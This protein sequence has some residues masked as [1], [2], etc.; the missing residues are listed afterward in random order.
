MPTL[1]ESLS[2]FQVWVGGAVVLGAAVWYLGLNTPSAKAKRAGA[3]LAPGPKRLPV[4]GNLFNFPKRKWYDTFTRWAK[5]YGDITYVDLAGTSMIVLN[6][7]GAIRELTEKRMNIHSNRVHATLVC[8]LMGSAYF[9]T[10]MQPTK[11]FAEQ[12]RLF[13][14][15]IGPRIVEQYDAFIQHGCSEL[16][17]Q[18]D[19]F[20]GEPIG[21]LTK[22]MGNVLTRIAYGERFFEQH[23]PEIIKYNIEGVE[24]IS[25]A[26]TQFWFVDVIPTLRYVPAWFP[27]AH[28][29]RVGNQGKYYSDMIRYLAFNRVKANMA[30]GLV[31][32]SI[33]SK[34][35]QEGSISEDNLRDAVAT[36]Y[37]AGV[38][39]TTITITHFLFSVALY[40]EWQQ[41]IHQE[42]DR[43]LGR[44]QLPTLGDTSKLETF[45]A[46]F[47]E[48]FRWNPPVPLGLPHVSSKE[49]VIDGYYIPKGSIVHCN[50]GFVLRDPRLWGEDSLDFNPNRFLAAHNPSVNELPDIWSIPFGFGRR[51]CPGRHLAQRS[52]LFYAAAILSAYEILPYEG[53]TLTPDGP[54][55]DSAVSQ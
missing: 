49:D 48:S 39:T 47:K 16:L 31:D 50:I 30:E 18:F 43:V 41:K 6:S 32:E 44:G 14:K 9:L 20:S 36:M 45:E 54:F 52:G 1:P 40:P 24:L 12:R 5:D 35:L 51:I 4:V 13:Q 26:F 28:F 46:V 38:D 53:E 27:G 3:A 8:D 7:F 19:G 2:S 34:Y 25:W 37:T 22:T 17:Q 33:L 10:L 11:N 55:E 29:K 21:I 23:G 42:M 15:A